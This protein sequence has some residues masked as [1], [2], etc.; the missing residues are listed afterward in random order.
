VELDNVILTPHVSGLSVQAS[1]DCTRTGVQ[2]LVAAL[3]GYLPPPENIVNKGLTPRFPLKPH[4]PA[5][6]AE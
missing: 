2:N 6:F 5:L 3:S 1:Q 4:D